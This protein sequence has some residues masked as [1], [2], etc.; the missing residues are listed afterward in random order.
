[1]IKMRQLERI[2]VN[3]KKN[4]I[5]LIGNTPLVELGNFSKSMGLARPILAKL[6]YLNP[7]GSSKDRPALSLIRDAEARGV[8]K[9]GGTI[10]EATSG[11]TGIGLA[12]VAAVLGYKMI[13]TMS[14]AASDERKM[15]L[16]MF[17]ATLIFTPREM[18]TEG[19]IMKAMELREALGDNVF[20]TNQHDNRANADA[21]L[22]TTG[23]EIWNETDG[24]LD[25]VVVGEGTGGTITGVGEFLKSKNP[26]I[27]IISVKPDMSE[28]I[29]RAAP[30]PGLGS[31]YIPSIINHGVIDRTI[32]VQIEPAFEYQ[33]KVTKT[34]GIFPGVSS[35][36]VLCAATQVAREN[37]D[38]QILV[39]FPDSGERY[40]STLVKRQ[41]DK[42]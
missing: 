31:T 30:I 3:I 41:K 40:T 36:A 8:L 38:K 29:G 24:K 16:K 22:H 25:I 42:P 2:T 6:E 5:E 15:Q 11:N 23:P 4:I 18:G 1:M 32:E 13:F 12:R 14:E 26:N 20:Y 19:A 33:D 35:G 17:G 21:H 10:L 7:G 39:I 9:P 34:D 28:A 37:P 27:Q